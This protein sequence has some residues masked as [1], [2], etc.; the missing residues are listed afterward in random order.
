MATLNTYPSSIS[1]K[2][3]IQTRM[4]ADLAAINAEVAAITTGSG[5]LVSSDDTTV[6]YLNGKL[7]AGEG[8]DFTEGSG[9]ADE[10]L[11]I[12]GEDASATNK[13]IVELATNTE[14]ETGTDTSRAVTPAG[15]KASVEQFS[16]LPKNYITGLTLSNDTD[17]DHDIAIA[18][19]ECRDSTDAAD[20]AISSV[21]TKQIDAT[22]AAGDDAGGMN[23]GMTV[24]NSTWYHVFV[25]KNVTTGGF[26]GGFDTSITAA[27][28]MA[29]AAVVAAGYTLYRRIG[30]V[31]TDGSANI[32]AF[33]QYGDTF[34]W[35]AAVFDVNVS[36]QGTTP[37]DYTLSV[38]TG[39]RV[40]PFISV[41]TYTVD[42][43]VKVYTKGTTEVAVSESWVTAAASAVDKEGTSGH[44]IVITDTSAQITADAQA[45][46][47]KLYIYT[48]GWKD[49]LGR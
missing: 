24:G 48:H 23:A 5:V 18:V 46:S 15:A 35:T 40:I 14:C 12:A 30:S 10:T 44:P 25:I 33:T 19:G 27:N 3:A 39:V 42:N 37:I 31:K 28:L 1:V 47:T 38:P 9:G 49:F 26:D 16:T 13:G 21:L 17:A 36:N 4:V 20:I 41:A 7:L 22:W 43:V 11:T 8:I 34:W 45:A 2:T 32:L 6:G 29:D